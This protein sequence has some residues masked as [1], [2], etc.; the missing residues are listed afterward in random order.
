[1]ALLK[2]REK[3]Y[4]KNLNIISAFQWTENIH[5]MVGWVKWGVNSLSPN[6]RALC[7]CWKAEI[8]F[9]QEKKKESI[10]SYV[11]R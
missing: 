10:K 2:I 11:G 5:V 7:D 1:M 8:K 9:P 6:N 3:F 4:L